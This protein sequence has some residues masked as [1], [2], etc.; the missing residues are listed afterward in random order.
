MS[1]KTGFPFFAVLFAFVVVGNCLYS[2]FSLEHNS[3]EEA[4]VY[5]ETLPLVSSE[6]NSPEEA[7]ID[8]EILPLFS[9]EQDSS[10][11]ADIDKEI[12]MFYDVFDSDILPKA[13]FAG[14]PL[15]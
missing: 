5:H 3:P 10:K 8:K 15:E 6:H 9:S 14:Y 7:D 13:K 11:E 12:A 2:V 1:E 4:G